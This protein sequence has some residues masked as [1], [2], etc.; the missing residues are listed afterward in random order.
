MERHQIEIGRQ[1]AYRENP[2][3]RDHPLRRVEVLQ[4]IKPNKWVVRLLDDPNAGVMATVRSE[5][6][7]VPWCER[8]EI[9]ERGAYR[10]FLR[11]ASE[12]RI[13]RAI[14]AVVRDLRR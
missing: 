2:R 3:R 9:G 5:T 1:Y 11:S 4:R 14:S 8:P 12:A 10:P 6:I 7:R 13:M